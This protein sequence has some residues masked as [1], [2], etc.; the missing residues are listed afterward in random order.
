MS[1]SAVAERIFRRAMRADFSD[2]LE[3]LATVAAEVLT[4]AWKLFR[5]SSSAHYFVF[6]EHVCMPFVECKK[7]YFPRLIK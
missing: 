4:G 1:F 7:H 3:L 2:A 6:V 5:S